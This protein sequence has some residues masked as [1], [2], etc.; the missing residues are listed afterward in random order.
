MTYQL[1]KNGIPVAVAHSVE[2]CDKLYMEYECD[3]VRGMSDKYILEEL[4]HKSFKNKEE[5]GNV[6]STN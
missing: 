1:F 3:E 2:E 5:K 4:V 6:N